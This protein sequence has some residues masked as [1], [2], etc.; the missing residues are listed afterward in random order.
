[1]LYRFHNDI[2][3]RNSF[4]NNFRFPQSYDYISSQVIKFRNVYSAASAN[5]HLPTTAISL[6]Q[7]A[8]Y[9]PKV[10]FYYKFDLS[11]VVN[12]LQQPLFAVL[13]LAVVGGDYNSHYLLTYCW[14]LLGVCTVFSSHFIPCCIY[15]P[16]S[17]PAPVQASAA[18]E[19]KNRQ[20][21]V[22]HL[23]PMEY[24][25]LTKWMSQFVK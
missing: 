2:I 22:T 21:I 7:P 24:S 18:A 11:I 1:M 3:N 5:G 14:L 16:H 10:Q 17:M 4:K 6:Y 23:C 13:L 25:I 19:I 8:F 12:S 20:A 15:V 9:I